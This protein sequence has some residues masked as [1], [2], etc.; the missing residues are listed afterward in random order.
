MTKQEAHHR[1]AFDA[2]YPQVKK[3]N[4]VQSLL[5]LVAERDERVS[6]G[7]PNKPLELAAELISEITN[8]L[9]VELTPLRVVNDK[10]KA[11]NENG[12]DRQPACQ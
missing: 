3:L 4:R 10:S 9:I 1:T 6:G 8:A 12:L 5:L 11:A 7:V 2:V